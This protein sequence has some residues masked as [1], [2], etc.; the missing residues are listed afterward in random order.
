MGLQD[1]KRAAAPE[2]IRTSTSAV[3]RDI[4]ALERMLAEGWIESGVRR[5]GAE[6]ELFL[7]DSDWR[8]APLVMELLEAL[9]DEAF[10]TEVGRFNLEINLEPMMFEA[11]VLSRF[12]AAVTHAVSRVREAAAAHEADIVLTGILPTLGTADLRLDNLTPRPRYAALN[13][14]VM[15]AAG[16]S[17]R[18][19]L[20]GTD[21]LRIDHDSVMLESCN[22]SF[23][24]HLQVSADEFPAFYNIAQLML[25]PALAASVNS[26]MLFGRR[27]WQETRIALFQQSVDTRRTSSH[28][29]DQAPRVWF[30]ESWVRESVVEVFL[31]NV[32]R[33]RVLMTSEEL[34]DPMTALD[35]GDVPE[36]HAL[37]LH[38][39]T[40]YR[41]NRPCYGVSNG[42][43]HLRIECRALPAGPTVK[44]QIAN[45]ALWLGLVLGGAA[46]LGDIAQSMA[47]DDAR[48]NFI[49]AARQG[50]GTGLM[51][52]DGERV[53][54][55]ELLIERLLPLARRG[56]AEAG[57]ADADAD[58]YLGVIEE[59]VSSGQTGAEW[60]L[61]S[62]AA[63]RD[64]TERTERM[65][66]L[67]AETSARALGAVPVSEWPVLSEAPARAAR[68]YSLVEHCMTTDLLTVNEDDALDLVAFLM[69]HKGVRQI[70]VED[71]DQRLTGIIS[72][73]SLLRLVSTGDVPVGQSVPVKDVMDRQPVTV[74]P[75]TSTLDA[76][77]LLRESEA[78]ALPVLSGGRLVG[79]VTEH[80]FIPIIEH[81]LEQQAEDE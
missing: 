72:Y 45:A 24:V 59:R 27:L 34:D 15:E 23:Q 37:R 49:A 33:Y 28:G 65:A 48:A 8:P 40:A 25:A 46:E 17:I 53:P 54:A 77:R 55:P 79:I 73:R 39:G 47:F 32:A 19:R 9:D 20:Q 64:Q 14:A 70:L 21:E 38:N 42:K 29:R 81:V 30:G 43:P 68:R 4:K 67:T 58:A 2:T 61:R 41:W 36:L 1:V 6:Q 10:T 18:L 35:A 57:V 62:D 16:G 50:L 78:S 22:T 76:I 13:E 31:E 3:L 5:I 60:L 75:Q 44:D 11:D 66:T 71:S 80:D 7:V 52:L 63:L 51:W 56:L 69:D 12:E 74:T 26:P